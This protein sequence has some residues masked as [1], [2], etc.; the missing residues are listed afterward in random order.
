MHDASCVR[1]RERVQQL[2]GGLH[3]MRVLQ[4]A[5]PHGVAQ[6]A[7]GN[8]L[9]RDVDVVIV[10]VDGVDAGAVPMAEPLDGDGF[11]FRPRSGLPLT[12]HHLQRDVASGDLVPGQ[13]DRPR[14]AATERPESAI[15]PE[16]QVGIG[17]RCCGLAHPLVRTLALTRRS[18]P[19][20]AAHPEVRTARCRPHC[21]ICSGDSGAKNRFASFLWPSGTD[22]TTTIS[23]STSSTSL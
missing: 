16:D 15:A 6:R 14:S 11:P 19:S 23:N 21:L 2:G 8:V 20:P 3:R 22:P 10:A 1:V 18:P 9:V 5:G 12:W 13:P 7:A 4:Q 17:V